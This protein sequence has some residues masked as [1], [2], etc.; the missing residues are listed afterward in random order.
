MTLYVPDTNSSTPAPE[1]LA[2]RQQVL[3][4]ITEELVG[5]CP[6][7]QAI[8]CDGDIIFWDEKMPHGAL[9]QAGSGEEILFNSPVIQY[10]IGVLYPP[11]STDSVEDEIFAHNNIVLGE[12]LTGD[13][14]SSSMQNSASKDIE[15][16]LRDLGENLTESETLDFDLSNPN[17]YRPSSIGL[18]FELFLPVGEQLQ[19][20]V[21]GGRYQSRQA[22]SK[23]DDALSNESVE[24][25]HSVPASQTLWLRSP[26]VTDALFSYDNLMHGE[27]HITLPSQTTASNLDG[28]RLSIGAYSRPHD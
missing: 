14:E 22:L 1:F 10:N 21:T 6:R 19:V 11:K 3:Q 15:G 8:D 13:N 9:R 4:A 27:E 26:I 7:G 23:S 20:H 24:N 25:V 5:P 16:I 28:L 2:G 12:A 18:S 17:S